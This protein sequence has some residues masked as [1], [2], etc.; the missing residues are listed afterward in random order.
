MYDN[1]FKGILKW[2][3]KSQ[4]DH[5]MCGFICM[6]YIFPTLYNLYQYYDKCVRAIVNPSVGAQARGYYDHFEGKEVEEEE[7]ANGS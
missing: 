1:D 7:K 2:P 4:P 6:Y 5:P 3:C